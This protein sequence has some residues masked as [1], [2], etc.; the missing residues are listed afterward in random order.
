MPKWAAD[1]T[2]AVETTQPALNLALEKLLEVL[3][4]RNL[5]HYGAGL[6]F[7]G[8]FSADVD[9]FKIIDINK[10]P[11]VSGVEADVEAEIPLQFRFFNFIPA[12]STLIFSINDVEI[13]LSKTPAGLPRG[14]VLNVTPTL[15]V[16]VNFNHKGG[17]L[18][19]ILNIVAAPLISFGVWLAFRIIRRVEIPV[20]EL[21]DIFAAL[22]IRYAQGSPL[23]TAQK[24]VPPPSLLLASDFNL[25]N[26][27]LGNPAQL[28]HFIPSNTNIGAV[29]HERIVAAAVQIAF[30]KGWVPQ[31]FRV[32]KFRIS[33]KSFSVRFEQDTVVAAGSL[34]GKR[35]V[36]WF[37]RVKL[38]IKFSMAVKPRVD[39]AA[40][41]PKIVFQWNANVRTHVSTSGVLV[42]LGVI[43]FAPLFLAL[44]IA[45]SFLINIVLQQ[46]LPFSTTWSQSGLV[47]TV[48]AKAAFSGFVPISMNF[49]LQ[50]SGT[51]TYPLTRF[52]QFSLPG[53]AVVNVGYTPESLSVQDKELRVAIELKK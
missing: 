7:F 34:R 44:T 28:G 43:M 33:I 41:D 42:I 16:N 47:L 6:G 36:F 37:F 4:S 26:T 31:V 29:V 18:S 2:A 50:L 20:W 15:T 23:L 9:S 22:G 27:L 24:A 51:G 30:T 52:Q 35:T 39:T 3:R 12:S 14:V 40:P 10:A 46:F 13:N 19:G 1:Y 53:G 48:Q 32:K 11:S 45:M 38:S 25:T 5:L 21:T 49:P 8:S 17:L